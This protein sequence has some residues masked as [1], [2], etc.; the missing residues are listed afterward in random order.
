VSCQR[1]HWTKHKKEC[2]KRVAELHDEA[3]F[4][5]PPDREECDICM[6]TLPLNPEEQKYQPCCGKVLCVGCIYSA[7]E[8]DNRKLCPFCRTP[9]ATSEGEALERI[10]KRAEGDDAVAIHQLGSYYCNG[11][12]GLPQDN[13]KAMELWLKAGELGC[14]SSYYNIGDC[15][16]FGQG[17][18]RDMKKAKQYYEF[19]AMGG[20]ATARNDLACV[21]AD[22]GNMDRAMK[23]WMISAGAGHD[24]SLK[25]IRECFFE[26]HATKDDFEKALRAHKEA[27]DDMRSDQREE[28]AAYRHLRR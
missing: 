12:M 6:L 26:G 23:H 15:Y 10:K 4:K 28:A 21:E 5:E 16:Y 22:A 2:K 14:M 20:V 7:F 25:N 1:A 8:A 19:A 3:L 9:A 17:V 27:Q 24:D 13:N 18:E 11:G